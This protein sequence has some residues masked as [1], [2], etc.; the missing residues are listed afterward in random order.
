[1]L[2]QRFMQIILD[3]RGRARPITHVITHTGNV[4]G[5][6]GR[7]SPVKLMKNTCNN[8]V[9]EY[10][11]IALKNIPYFEIHEG[12]IF[13]GKDRRRLGQCGNVFAEIRIA[14]KFRF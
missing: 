11:N 5:I 3:F 9:E 10:W 6:G 2:P 4:T 7:L 14:R 8:N 13:F 12:I 1:M